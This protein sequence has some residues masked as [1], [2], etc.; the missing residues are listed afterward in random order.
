ML[1]KFESGL[2]PFIM[3][4]QLPDALGTTTYIIDA[5]YYVVRTN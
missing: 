3:Y 1:G 4:R 2:D 5:I